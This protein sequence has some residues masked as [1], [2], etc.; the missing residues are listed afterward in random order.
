MTRLKESI[1][2]T[3]MKIIELFNKIEAGALILEPD[4]QRKLVWKKQHKI[5]F[6]ET[7]LMNYPFPEIYIA[8]AEINV[9]TIMAQEIVVDGQQRLS[10]IVS[11]IKS[12][13]DFESQLK[14]P[15]FEKLDTDIKKNFLNYLVTV[16]DL[17]DMSI[18]NIKE[19]FQ[20]IN[21]T[22]YSLNT[23]EKRNA[24]FGDGE[25]IIFC[26]QILEKDYNPSEEI[27]DVII[28]SDSKKILNDFFE[29]YQIFNE[30][31]LKRMYA[32]QV[33][34][35]IVATL[36][37][38]EYFTRFRKVDE[39]IEQYNDYF[40]R[41]VDV[42]EKLVNIFEF[43]DKLELNSKSY[44]FTKANIFSLIL[45]LSKVDL[46]SIDIESLKTA[47]NDFELES[48]QYFAEINI[49]NIP[50]ENVKY[51]EYA[52]EAINEKKSR[53]HRGSIINKIIR[54]S[55]FE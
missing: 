32:L 27:T 21:N 18:E 44:W 28:D 9:D 8:S 1:P 24:Q 10:T 39:F 31:D 26:K 42:T 49:E 45:E 12:E 46:S 30:N 13:G 48:K 51:F 38:S 29:K 14:I 40:D 20:R 7:I 54:L 33:V 11:Y 47:L 23:V 41:A 50:A 15:P 55:T 17:K 22:E 16:K 4:F 52:K 6:I 3:N 2:S 25:F 37:Y 35:S 43:I 5:H 19:I 36:V 53:E 34:M